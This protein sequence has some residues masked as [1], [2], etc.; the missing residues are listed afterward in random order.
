MHDKYG[1]MPM[2]DPIQDPVVSLLPSL[3]GMLSVL[4][5]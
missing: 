1:D 5:A 2:S 3:L 4:E